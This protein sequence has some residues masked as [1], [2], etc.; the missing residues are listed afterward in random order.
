MRTYMRGNLYIIQRLELGCGRFAVI[1]Q[2]MLWWR[3]IAVLW[4]QM[5]TP[6]KILLWDRIIPILHCLSH[7]GLQIHLISLMNMPAKYVKEPMICQMGELL[8]RSMAIYSVDVVQR[9]AAS[10]KDFWS[11]H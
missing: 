11:L 7:I 6:I 2:V 1:R 5:V 9:P 3:I 4:Q 10:L 8:F